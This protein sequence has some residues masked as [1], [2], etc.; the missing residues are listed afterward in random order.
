MKPFAD[1]YALYYDLLYRDKD[2]QTEADYITT[3]IRQYHPQA[4]SL[5]IWVVVPVSMHNVLPGKAGVCMAWTAA[6]ACWR[7]PMPELDP[8]S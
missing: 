3:L 1:L 4:K 2:Y 7:W 5:L 6:A 8:G